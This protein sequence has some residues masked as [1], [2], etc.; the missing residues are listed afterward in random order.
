MVLWFAGLSVVGAFVVFRDA[1]L[2]YR[3]V[4]FGALLPDIVD[5]VARRGVGPAHS[6]SA[7][8]AFMAIVMLATV[9][10]RRTR[11]RLLALPIGTFAHLILDGAWDLTSV[12][13]WP[14]TRAPWGAALPSVE[15]GSWVVA[16]EII[17]A[18]AMLWCWHRFGLSSPTRRQKFFASGRLDRA[19]V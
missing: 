13:W 19:V 9:G 6:V 14:F 10:R 15:R 12:F 5:L 8:A 16:M 11:R 2:D 18:A 17:G 3:L 1:A 7:S 4:A